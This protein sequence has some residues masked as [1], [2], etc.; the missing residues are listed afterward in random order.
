MMATILLQG[1]CPCC[2]YRN[3]GLRVG[4][5]RPGMR[6]LRLQPGSLAYTPPACAECGHPLDPGLFDRWVL[7]A[8]T[9]AQLKVWQ[10]RQ[11]DRRQR[12][13]AA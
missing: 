13:G 7:D 1:D 3:K 4:A 12:K 6:Q 2:G 9:T 10:Q 8:E 5:A 11:R